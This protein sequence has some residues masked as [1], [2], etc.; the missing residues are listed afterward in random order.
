[1]TS[2]ADRTLGSRR[3]LHDILPVH[4]GI[5]FSLGVFSPSRP[6]TLT[7]Y[8]L[9]GIAAATSGI[10][11]PRCSDCGPEARF[12]LRSNDGWSSV[13]CVSFSCTSS[14][15][16]RSDGNENT[17]WVRFHRVVFGSARQGGRLQ[18][19]SSEHFER[20]PAPRGCEGIWRTYLCER[21][22][23]SSCAT[24][25]RTGTGAWLCAGL[26]IFCLLRLTRNT[27]WILLG[28]DGYQYLSEARNI[29]TGNGFST[30][31]LNFDENLR[32]GI[33]P[34]PQTAFPPGY[35][36]A[37]AG[38]QF[39]G[40]DGEAAGVAVSLA[41][42][43]C[44]MAL[45]IYI[46]RLLDIRTGALRCVLFMVLCSGA[47]WAL[48]VSVASDSLFTAITLLGLGFLLSGESLE[49]R[50]RARTC[51]LVIGCCIV[52]LSFWVRYAGC[53]L[54]ATVWFYFAT[55]WLMVRRRDRFCDAALA[56]VIL[57]TLVLPL[58]I[59]NALLVEYR[60]GGTQSDQQAPFGDLWGVPSR[61][62]A[63]VYWLCRP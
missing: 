30:S 27:N 61:L 62:G 55:R 43:A 51:Y 28:N 14:S 3:S 38:V 39:L 33:I 42:F 29:I 19:S 16:S 41:S 59:R 20:P 46:G 5:R 31:L 21:L 57:A 1:M 6:Y 49:D 54:I 17:Q 47:S 10:A 11:A 13:S 18:C 34:A 44:T 60:G 36:I 4:G 48:A 24:W 50:P 35:S 52:G 32:P 40:A 63:V 23:I 37:I 8:M 2:A 12:V 58:W 45:L 9:L 15:E 56:T 26:A 7:T 22:R 53:F 25:A